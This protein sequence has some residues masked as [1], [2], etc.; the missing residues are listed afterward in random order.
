MPNNDTETNWKQINDGVRLCATELQKWTK[1]NER[2]DVV[3]MESKPEDETIVVGNFHMRCAGFEVS[4]VYSFIKIKV[5]TFE[6]HEFVFGFLTLRSML[7][8]EEK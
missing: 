2:M 1:K 7:R 5:N 3:C 8:S 4:I 6:V